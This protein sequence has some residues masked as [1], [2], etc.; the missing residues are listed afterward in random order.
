[1]GLS[2]AGKL[3]LKCP[4]PLAYLRRRDGFFPY[5]VYLTMGL[6]GVIAYF[7]LGGHNLYSPSTKDIFF[8]VV[9]GSVVALLF[10][11]LTKYLTKYTAVTFFAENGIS[12][13]VGR[14]AA[15]SA[16][17]NITA[18]QI[19]PTQSGNMAFYILKFTLM[20][21]D[22]GFSSLFGSQVTTVAVTE[23]MLEPVLQILRDKAVKVIEKQAGLA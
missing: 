16:Y 15:F 21:S 11:L 4:V 22:D 18:C 20:K 14:S 5:V 8:A 13:M 6:C 12:M 7:G 10:R 2:R 23:N 19:T 3:I 9:I 1:M 17:K